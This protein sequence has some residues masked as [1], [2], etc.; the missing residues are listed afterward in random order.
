LA[1]HQVSYVPVF[2]VGAYKV[3]N[4][5]KTL[6]PELIEDIESRHTEPVIGIG[7]SFGGVLTLWAAMKRPDLFKKIILIDPPFMSRARRFSIALTALLGITDKVVPIARNA[8]RR[9]ADFASLDEARNYWK[10][11]FLF[12]SFHPQCFED[13]VQHSLVP[14][15]EGFT[16][17]IPPSLESQFFST[18]PFRIGP[19]N[20]AMPSYYLYPLQH[21]VLSG[22]ALAQH[23]KKFAG[24]EFIP[25]EKGG[26]MFP[27][28]FPHE[29][30]DF[31]KELIARE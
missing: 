3:R 31:I 1:P 26:H 16:L 21:G 24:T 15:E 4:T 8:K 27:L 22:N 17:K 28:E 12:R 7:H 20:L 2:G 29:T 10:P 11:K 13:Y 23:K 25:F 9:K 5:W 6:V 30:A 19:A 18:T 14:S